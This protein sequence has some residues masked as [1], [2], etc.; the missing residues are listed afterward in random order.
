MSEETRMQRHDLAEFTLPRYVVVEGPIGA[1]KTTL[2]KLL[3]ETFNYDMLL[4]APEDNPFLHRFYAGE[5][6]AALSTQLFFLMQRAQLLTRIQQNDLFSPVR[7]ADFLME[8]DHLFAEVTLDQDELALYEQVYQ[9]L[10]LNAPKPDLVIYLQA[11]PDIL[12]ERIQQR[13]IDAEQSIDTPYLQRL[14]EAYS[15]FFHFYDQA[16]L[17]IINAAS[18]D[19]VN[20]AEDYN[21]LVRYMLNITSGRHYYNPQ[22]A[23]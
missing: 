23:I 5:K 22:A 7:V 9:H 1:G 12:L 3:A 4:E 10:T 16:P 17:L 13:G 18:L 2:T 15:R 11:T 6:N 21:N 19:W 8:K 14:N 20:N